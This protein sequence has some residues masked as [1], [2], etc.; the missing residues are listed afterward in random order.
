MFFWNSFYKLLTWALANHIDDKST[1]VQVMGC[2]YLSQCWPRSMS[3]HGVTRPQWF[4]WDLSLSWERKAFQDFNKC[5]RRMYVLL[6]DVIKTSLKHPNRK[7]NTTLCLTMNVNNPSI[8][9]DTVGNNLTAIV[10]FSLHWFCFV[11]T[12]VKRRICFS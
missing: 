7:A 10:I 8:N 1:L 6:K 12:H 9:N 11:C 3:T 5:I 2:I 4:E